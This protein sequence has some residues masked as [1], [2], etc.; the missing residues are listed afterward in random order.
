MEKLKT[1]VINFDNPIAIWEIPA[2]RGAI[3]E[4]VGQEDSMLFHN[5]LGDG[6]RYSYPLIQYKRIRGN[7]AIFC[8]KEGVEEIGK[9]FSQCDFQVAIGERIEKLHVADINAEQTI[10]Q[11]WDDMFTYYLNNW[12]PLQEDN[13]QKYIKLE[14]IAEKTQFLER[15]LI[16][17]ILSFCKGVDITIDKE[18]ICKIVQIDAPRVVKFKDI[19]K[20]NFEVV[21]KSNVSLPNYMGLGKGA[22]VGHGMVVRKYERKENDNK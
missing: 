7:A 2:F 13:Y 18:I 10:V 22:S 1:L 5:H 12:I 4:K 17:N 16:G 20:L 6:F 3:I 11:V 14:G 9:F 21:F 19:F 8:V 15:I